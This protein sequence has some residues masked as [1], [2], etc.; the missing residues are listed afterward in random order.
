MLG[1][2][3]IVKALGVRGTVAAGLALVLAIVAG[4]QTWRL[5]SLQATHAAVE[6]NNAILADAVG[7]WQRAH[8]DQVNAASSWKDVARIRLTLLL[9]AQKETLRLGNANRDALAAAAAQLAESDRVRRVAEDRL[10]AAKRTSTCG[11]ALAAL[12]TAC[13]TLE[14]F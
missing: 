6:A 11:A 2:L 10:R 5:H 8:T 14:G 12:D 3:A 4:A 1:G 13:P 7:D 9:A